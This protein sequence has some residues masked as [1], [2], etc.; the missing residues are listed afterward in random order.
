ML[1]YIF[2]LY[3]FVFVQSIVICL[4]ILDECVSSRTKKPT[5]NGGKR[6]ET[7]AK[8]ENFVKKQAKLPQLPQT[9][10]SFH[11]SSCNCIE[12]KHFKKFI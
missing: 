5:S 9:C 1:F 6:L 7:V 8:E 12:C 4:F 11:Y 10:N 3:Q 2:I